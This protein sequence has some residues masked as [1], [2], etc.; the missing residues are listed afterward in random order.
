MRVSSGIDKTTEF[1]THSLYK[2]SCQINIDI[3]QVLTGGFAR[4]LPCHSSKHMSGKRGFSSG[5]QL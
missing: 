1:V 5:F 4:Y 3:L 2:R